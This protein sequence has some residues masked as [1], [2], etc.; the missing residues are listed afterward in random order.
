MGLR[1]G[2]KLEEGAI[3]EARRYL[4]GMTPGFRKMLHHFLSDL[5]TVDVRPL[6]S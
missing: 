3:R 1:G 2:Q 5:T 4:G 6:F